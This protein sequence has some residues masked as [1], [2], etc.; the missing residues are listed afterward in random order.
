MLG[1]IF[2][3][4]A[5]GAAKNHRFE[6]VGIRG[7]RIT[8]KADLNVGTVGSIC[9]I[10]RTDEK[11]RLTILGQGE[12]VE[13]RSGYAYIRV[14]EAVSFRIEI[15]DLVEIDAIAGAA[16]NVPPHQATQPPQEPPVQSVE[17]KMDEPEDQKGQNNYIF[18][19]GQASAGAHDQK[20][21]I[22]ELG[23]F[24]HRN[25]SGA[26]ENQVPN[27]IGGELRG[28]RFMS[29]RSTISTLAAFLKY[30]FPLNNAGYANSGV[31]ISSE[32]WGGLIGLGYHLHARARLEANGEWLAKA[33]TDLHLKAEFF[34]N[35]E[36]TL[37]V[38][39]GVYAQ[40]GI[41]LRTEFV[42]GVA[43]SSP[44]DKYTE[45]LYATIGLVLTPNSPAR[46]TGRGGLAWD[47]LGNIGIIG[48]C[49]VGFFF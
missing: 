27:K 15:G 34:L 47:Q 30:S 17:L 38:Q 5:I 10:V 18:F 40:R 6:V 26:S 36:S 13:S 4:T 3:V 24:R 42:S 49:E 19:A 33:Y 20:F 32:S 46:L 12:V 21:F 45:L 25:R 35:H 22:G 41:G 43:L 28:Y 8:I 14:S 9:K 16:V 1:L 37:I 48:R 31:Q 44:Y 29:P 39:G 2:F 11:G 23:Y 7:E